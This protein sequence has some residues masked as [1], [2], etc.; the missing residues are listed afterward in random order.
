MPKAALKH[1]GGGGL[2]F[3]AN[4]RGHHP[5]AVRESSFCQKQGRGRQKH[6]GAPEDARGGAIFSGSPARREKA[7]LRQS[8]NEGR[9]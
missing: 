5:R 3:P 8:G 6:G 1:G 4:G 2:L 9:D 7:A